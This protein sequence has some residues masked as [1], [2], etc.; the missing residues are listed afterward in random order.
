MVCQRLALLYLFLDKYIAMA[1]STSRIR[2][3]LIPFTNGRVF[4]NLAIIRVDSCNNAD[5]P[6]RVFD[7]KIPW[8]GH[9]V[10][11]SGVT[12]LVGAEIV[13]DAAWHLVNIFELTTYL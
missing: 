13:I 9:P 7:D 11:S 2:D 5:K 1:L 4:E 8:S 10:Y 12:Y 6:W 3:L